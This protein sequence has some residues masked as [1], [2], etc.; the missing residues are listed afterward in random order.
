MKGVI[1]FQQPMIVTRLL[2]WT[3]RRAF[4]IKS[5]AVKHALI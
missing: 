1:A 4:I 3:K 5:V 2:V